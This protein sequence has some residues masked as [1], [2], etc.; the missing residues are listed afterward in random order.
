ML[1]LIGLGL[2][3]EKDITIKGFEIIKKCDL[4]YLE[5]YTSK[6]Q[7][8]LKELEKLYGKKIIPATREDV[9]SDENA[10]EDDEKSKNPILKNAKTK[11]ADGK[12]RNVALLVIGDPMGATT[13]VDLLLRCRKQGIKTEVV[14]NASIINAVG[15]VGLEL[16]KYGKTTSIPFPEKSFQPET[17]YDVINL[18][19]KNGLHT[20]CL[21]DLK[22]LENKF[23]SV[24]DA[25]K[26]LLE[27][28]EK[29]KVKGTENPKE[30]ETANGTE[31]KP[32]FTKNTFCIGCARIGSDNLIKAGKAEKLLK[33]NFGNPPHCLIVPAKMHFMEEEALKMWK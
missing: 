20:L 18:N 13:H 4:I 7:C 10:A 16:Y 31:R 11:G 1:Y 28:G 25:I 5:N 15:I 8:S 3:D 33:E 24:N 19:K 14:H 17:A 32:I 9:E 27:I 22:P 21:L 2:G 12:Q 30:T 26:I 6:L 23:M 29:R